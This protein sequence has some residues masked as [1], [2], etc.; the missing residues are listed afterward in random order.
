M[1]VLTVEMVAVRI[2][3]P[4]T[5]RE[6]PKRGWFAVLDY[7]LE[8]VGLLKIDPGTKHHFIAPVP[9]AI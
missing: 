2:H 9:C 3:G 4:V 8:E 1:L 7:Q 5:R 6:H